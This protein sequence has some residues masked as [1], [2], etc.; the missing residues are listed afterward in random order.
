MRIDRRLNLVQ[1]VETETGTIYLHSVPIS[2]DVW[3]TYFLTLSKTY[4]AILSEGLNV[5]AGPP[6]AK[7]MLKRIAVIGQSWEGPEGVE[8]GL[9]GE[10]RRLTNVALPTGAGW[11]TLPYDEI[12]RRGLMDED[13]VADAEGLL[14][15]FT[16]VSAVLRGP[17]SKGKRDILLGGLSLWSASTTSLDCMAYVA[18]LPTSTPDGTSAPKPKTSSIPH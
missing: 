6:I 3:E 5:L 2:R 8:Q 10:I 7:M 11:E 16:C 4:A 12:L 1:P 17:A 15:F 14:V 18:S 9:L 13:A